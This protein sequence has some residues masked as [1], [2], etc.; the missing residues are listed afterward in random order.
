M[1]VARISNDIGS[2][3]GAKTYAV[4]DAPQPILN[5]PRN[6][7]EPLPAP[8]ER[9]LSQLFGYDL[10]AVRVQTRSEVA[11]CGA[12]ALTRGSNIYFAPGEYSP[13]TFEGAQL[14]GHELAHVVQQ[15]ANEETVSSDADTVVFDA[16]LEAAADRMG[17]L[18]AWALADRAGENGDSGA[19]GLR[20]LQRRTQGVF[21]PKVT[22]KS[23]AEG[24]PATLE[25]LI[26]AVFRC[27]DK[28]NA[29]HKYFAT[30]KASMKELDKCDSLLRD[31][32]GKPR[33]PRV[34]R[35]SINMEFDDPEE[36]ARAL[37]GQIRSKR[38]K[39]VEKA[40][41]KQAMK[42]RWIRNNLVAYVIKIRDLIKVWPEMQEHLK[43]EK[44][45]RYS[46]YYSKKLHTSRTLL[47]ALNVM[48]EKSVVKQA[49]FCADMSMVLRDV[50]DGKHYKGMDDE[51]S[52]AK[53]KQFVGGR[54]THWNVNESNNWV[55]TARE[56]HYV[57]GAGPS[58]TTLTTLAVADYLHDQ[59]I[60]PIESVTNIMTALAWG[61]FAF[62]ND[63]DGTI[64]GNWKGAVH[65]FHEVMMV[66]EEYGV[67]YRFDKYP[68]TIPPE[69]TYPEV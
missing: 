14:L 7:G 32:A 34:P 49:A 46:Y 29:P 40:L 68:N 42:S 23:I 57:L 66:A 60:I 17:L 8:I 58:A 16:A 3:V 38:S 10:S 26:K 50:M 25:E 59:G 65:T 9:R 13:A 37:L 2:V 39:E 45:G 54:K 30:A 6:G 18:S 15:C 69:L 12:R 56:N 27:G 22:V 55:K 48:H 53:S 51:N 31:W 19:R 35:Q 33:H 21:Q 4:F 44:P 5:L 28:G 47:D 61:L 41:A 52:S 67:Q 11:A 36:V 43:Q 64:L 63:I 24:R 20:P 62:W 1:S